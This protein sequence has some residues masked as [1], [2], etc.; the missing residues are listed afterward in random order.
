MATKI[1]TGL[2][3]SGKTCGMR[4]QQDLLAGASHFYYHRETILSK[5]KSEGFA[6]NVDSIGLAK[7][8]FGFQLKIKDPFF[9]F[10][11]NFIEQ[12]IHA[13]VPL[14]SAMFQATS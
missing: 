1:R 8:A 12:R 5:G 11:K 2:N 4:G 9:I 14:S 7:S 10:T 3:V 6:M 13:L